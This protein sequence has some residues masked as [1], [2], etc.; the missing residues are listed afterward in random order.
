MN[1]KQ[2]KSIRSDIPVAK[3]VQHTEYAEQLR[4]HQMLEELLV[5]VFQRKMSY[6]LL[7]CFQTRFCCKENAKINW[8]HNKNNNV[9]SKRLTISSNSNNLPM[10]YVEFITIHIIFILPYYWIV[11]KH[12][13][14][15]RN[16]QSH[17]KLVQMNTVMPTSI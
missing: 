16:M 14:K 13:Q 3:S 10:K 11:T 6:P 2:R 15:S 8:L 7:R 5:I 4:R 17:C 9:W 1:R 12:I